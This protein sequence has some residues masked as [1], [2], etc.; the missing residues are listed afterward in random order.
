MQQ[1]LINRVKCMTLD[2]INQASTFIDKSKLYLVPW[3][4]VLGGIWIFNIFNWIIGSRLTI[5]G[6]YPRHL[7]GLIGIP[8]A[9]FL[10]ADFNHLFFNSIPLFVLGLA[11]ITMSP[12]MF[13]WVTLVVI[14]L[15][16]LGVWLLGRKALHI[17]ASGV[18]SGY[19][20]YILINAYKQPS[21]ITVVLACLAVYYFGGIFLGLFPR[22][23]KVSWET[24]L[25]GFLSGILCAYI[26]N[27]LAYFNLS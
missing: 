18:I 7:F 17:G 3:L 27:G 8:I 5:F 1:P 11:L 25:F 20:G 21:V 19:F 16:G 4:W 9:P 13:I 12:E 23:E 22:E 6:I 24:H 26:P 14:L 2:F 15:S 10:H